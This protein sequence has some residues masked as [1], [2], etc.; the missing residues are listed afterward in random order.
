MTGDTPTSTSHSSNSSHS[1][2]Q[3]I[4]VCVCVCVR[5][6]VLPHPAHW[7]QITPS[8]F[9]KTPWPQTEPK[10]LKNVNNAESVGDQASQ[11]ET[12][13]FI[14][15]SGIIICHTKIC[16]ESW[17]TLRKFK[18]K[19]LST[20]GTGMKHTWNINRSIRV[21]Q[22]TCLQ[23]C[24][25]PKPKCKNKPVKKIQKIEVKETEN[26]STHLVQLYR[27]NPLESVLGIFCSE[28]PNTVVHTDVKTTLVKL[29]RLQRERERGEGSW[30]VIRQSAWVMSG[31]TIIICVSIPTYKN[32]V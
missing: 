18:K 28:V 5:I 11:Q 21:M 20:T 17:Q 16:S 12:S 3:G 7:K 25:I 1:Q 24:K 32:S 15:A 23:I 2:G 8:L 26:H 13:I 31:N 19:S 14:M 29:M 9:W 27:L 30:I 10:H 4:W 6:P 22:L